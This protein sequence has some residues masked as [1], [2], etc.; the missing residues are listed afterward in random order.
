[1]QAV[2]PTISTIFSPQFWAISIWLSPTGSLAKIP[3]SCSS[4]QRRLPYGQNHLPNNSSPSPRGESLSKKQHHFETLSSNPHPLFSMAAT[5]PLT[6]ILVKMSGQCRLTKANSARSSRISY[7]TPDMP[8][9]REG[10]F[11]LAVIIY[12]KTSRFPRLPNFLEITSFI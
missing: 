3:A 6:T 9:R 2:S 11:I 5:Y 12:P 10:P 7:S 1:M 4:T 8:C